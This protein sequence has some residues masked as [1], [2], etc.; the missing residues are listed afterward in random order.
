MAEQ[1]KKTGNPGS[2]RAQDEKVSDRDLE[3][4]SGGTSSPHTQTGWTTADGLPE[5]PPSGPAPKPA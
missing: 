3:K 1:E 5:A 4:V 2:E